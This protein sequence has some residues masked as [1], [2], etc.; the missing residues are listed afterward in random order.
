[1]DRIRGDRDKRE[2]Y[3]RTLERARTAL[4]Q[5]L[6]DV[7]PTFHFSPFPLLTLTVLVQLQHEREAERRAAF[8]NKTPKDPTL[9]R[10]GEALSSEKKV[11]E[12]AE[13]NVVRPPLPPFPSPFLLTHLC[14]SQS[15]LRSEVQH[16]EAALEV[17]KSTAADYK[18]RMSVLER[19]LQTVAASDHTQNVISPSTQQKSY[20]APSPIT[21]KEPVPRRM[22]E[23]RVANALPEPVPTV[24]SR[25]GGGG[26]T[27]G[28]YGHGYG[29]VH[30]NRSASSLSSLPPPSLTSFTLIRLGRYQ[31]R[32]PPVF[33]Y[34]F[35]RRQLSRP[36]T[37]LRVA[38]LS[39]PTPHP[40]FVRFSF[41]LL[42]LLTFP[43]ATGVYLSLH[44]HSH[45]PHLCHSS[46]HTPLSVSSS[47]VASPSF[48]YRF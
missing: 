4:T 19:E 30:A 48:S 7:R 44:R 40:L 34:S 33:H 10:L 16:L 28:P 22:G 5:S 8:A 47:I 42:P 31:A 45:T 12:L 17:A 11:R 35:N 41:V 32:F 3:V 2:A 9:D 15:R 26:V 20:Y 37:S 39:P 27:E 46:P 25:G 1:M 38:T 24:S 6:E 29:G 18:K 14:L 21:V 23:S 13:L 36:S 43:S